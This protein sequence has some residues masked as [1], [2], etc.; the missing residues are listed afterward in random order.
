MRQPSL[1]HQALDAPHAF[2]PLKI[3]LHRHAVEAGLGGGGDFDFAAGA[4]EGFVA[5]DWGPGS[6]SRGALELVVPAGAAAEA[7]GGLGGG[8]VVGDQLEDARGVGG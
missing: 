4:G 3:L 7:Q 2:P 6:E 8:E 1:L 5:G